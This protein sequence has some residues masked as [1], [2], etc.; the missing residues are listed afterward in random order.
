MRGRRLLDAECGNGYFSRILAGR[1]A[2]VTAV[3]PTEL[4]CAFAREREAALRQGITYVQADLTRP[5]DLGA[6]FDAVL[7]SMVLMAIPDWKPAMRACVEA[8]RLV[9]V[10]Q[11]TRPPRLPPA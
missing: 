2:Q 5:P 6:P 10:P 4:M 8:V 9:G 7:C 3:E 11:R 1:G